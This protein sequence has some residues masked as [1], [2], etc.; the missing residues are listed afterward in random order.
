MAEMHMPVEADGVAEVVGE[1]VVAASATDLVQLL[2]DAGARALVVR[3]D[4]LPREFFDLASG[5]AGEVVQKFVNYGLRLAVVGDFERGRSRS[6]RAFVAESNR[7]GRILFVASV[8]EAR[9]ALAGAA[10]G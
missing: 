4:Q 9:T 6:W 3:E 8:E 10:K 1:G 7:T 2:F 5:F